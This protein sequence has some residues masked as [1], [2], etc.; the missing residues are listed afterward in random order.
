MKNGFV[1]VFGCSDDL[2]EIEGDIREEYP[3]YDNDDDC[4]YLSFSDGTVLKIIYDDDGLWR[5]SLITRGGCEFEKV[6]G[7][8][9]EDTND[10]VTLKGELSWVVIGYTF[11]VAT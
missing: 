6:E 8:V 3:F 4:R 2:V 11:T 10:I 1:K 9:I 7:S 5:V